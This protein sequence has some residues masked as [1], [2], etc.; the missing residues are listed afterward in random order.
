MDFSKARQNM[1]DSQIRPNGIT[2]PGLIA[3]MDEI[4]RELFVPEDKK[5]LAYAED[6]LDLANGRVLLPPMVT[7]KLLQLAQINPSDLVLDVGSAS[8]YSAALAANLAESVVGI[9]QDNDLCAQ[10]GENLIDLKITNA[11]IICGQHDKGVPAEAPFDVIILNGRVG[12]VPQNLLDQLGEAGRLVA[13]VGDANNARFEVIT[14]RDRAFSTLRT[15]NVFA[16]VL[17]GFEK[18]EPAFS[19]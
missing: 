16:P 7:G 2:N 4:P 13:I 1:V 14:R 17:T 18:P 11:A 5:W 6:D 10:A 3:A 15:F 12:Q 9:E 8:G 19:F